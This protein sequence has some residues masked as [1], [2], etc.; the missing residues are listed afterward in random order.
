MKKRNDTTIGITMER[1][2]KLEKAALEVSNKA[3][4]IVKKSI[5]VNQL[6]DKYLTDAKNDI[7]NKID[8]L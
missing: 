5:I 4:K 8:D 6:I 3:G 7:I 1:N 2:L